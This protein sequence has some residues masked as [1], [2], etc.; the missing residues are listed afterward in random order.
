MR[1]LVVEDDL[2]LG[3]GVAAALRHDGYT[4]DWLRDGGQ[5]ETALMAGG[6]DA[7][8]LDLGLPGQDGLTVLRSCRRMGNTLPVLI[9]TARDGVEDRI[10]GLDAGA[11]DYL[12]KP[13][14]L[15]ELRARL[16]ALLR[17]A[18][19]KAGPEYAVG[20]LAVDPAH[21]SATWDGQPL[22][23][24][25]REFQILHALARSYPRV[26][27]RTQLEDALYG[28]SQEVDSNAVEVHIHHLRRK[29]GKAAIST[30]RGVGYRLV[31]ES[32]DG[33]RH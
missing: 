2:L 31:D 7:V 12:L 29:L 6:F 9:L 19:G 30:V 15:G 10:A 16:R 33:A 21:R 22:E 14:A 32:A 25:V 11:D 20:R 27:S 5:A 28:W 17:R 13:F 26:L 1:V 23:L 24:S 3:D 4:V 18:A 8:V